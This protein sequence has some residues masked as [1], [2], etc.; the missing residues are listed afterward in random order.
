MIV[1]SGLTPEQRRASIRYAN[2]YRELRALCVQALV[3]A[4]WIERA[5]TLRQ[6]DKKV[7][8]KEIYWWVIDEISKFNLYPTDPRTGKQRRISNRHVRRIAAEAGL[9]AASTRRSAGRH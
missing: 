6:K 3:V 7:L 5:A 4:L 9:T 1:G 2:I 8:D